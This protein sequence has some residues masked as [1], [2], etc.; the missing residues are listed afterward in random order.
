MTLFRTKERRWH[1]GEREQN[2]RVRAERLAVFWVVCAA[3]CSG[4]DCLGCAVYTLTARE[5]L[6][7]IYYKHRWCCNIVGV[8]RC[9]TQTCDCDGDLKH[10]GTSQSYE[11]EEDEGGDQR[12]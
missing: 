4:C 11:C 7:C 12:Q 10:H 8:A 3:E 9:Q 5:R 2:Q 6:G 1:V